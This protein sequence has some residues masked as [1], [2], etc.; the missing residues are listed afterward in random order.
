MTQYQSNAAAVASDRDTHDDKYELY[1]EL[2]DPRYAEYRQHRRRPPRK[3]PTARRD[4]HKIVADLTD[5]L[6]GLEG[7]FTPTYQPSRYEGEWLLDSLRTFYEQALIT[8]VV[9]MVKGGKE[10]SVYRCAAHPSTGQ[11][12]LAA[13]V[14]R[15]QKFRSLSND[16][17]YREGR[18]TLTAE[19]HSVRPTEHRILRALGKKTA[20]GRQVAHTSWLMYEHTTLQ[21]L[22]KAGGA[23]PRPFGAGENTVLMSYRG[24][25]RMP[26]PTLNQVRLRPAEAEPLFREVLRNVELMLDH[27]LIHGDL[28]AY[29]LL[30]WEGRITLIDFPQVVNVYNNVNAYII[31][32][33]DVQRVCEYFAAQGVDDALCDADT[34][35]ADLWQRYV[36][37]IPSPRELA[38]SLMQMTE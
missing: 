30:Y 38:A 32:Q 4:H 19:G 7:G 8:D 10:A 14:Y 35:V 15:P 13:K 27:E 20:F 2:Y 33:R 29:N 6:R 1:E 11:T 12:W 36:G 37:R 31:F 9:A 18:A 21:T 34:I 22:Y 24:D 23:V 25:A 5:D 16:Q 17:L 28:S 26:A 3:Q